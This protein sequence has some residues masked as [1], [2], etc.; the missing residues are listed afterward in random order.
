[1]VRS[2]SVAAATALLF[3]SCATQRFCDALIYGHTKDVAEADITRSL[4]ELLLQLALIVEQQF[5]ITHHIHKKDVPNLQPNVRIRLSGR[6][7][8]HS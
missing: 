6:G 7:C 4:R 8:F 3:G 2:M 5:R 1:M